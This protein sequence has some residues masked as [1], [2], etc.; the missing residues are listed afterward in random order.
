MSQVDFGNRSPVIA[1]AHM[2]RNVGRNGD[3][4][5]SSVPS[6][7]LSPLIP[8]VTPGYDGRP[9]SPGGGH[10]Q[11]NLTRSSSRNEN[12]SVL[13]SPYSEIGHAANLNWANTPLPP[14][15]PD[16]NGVA[17]AGIARSP[18]A[19]GGGF[20][21]GV[22]HSDMRAYQ[23]ALEADSDKQGA[24]GRLSQDPGNDPPP[25]YFPAR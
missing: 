18:S 9:L 16:A 6:T 4:S 24:S 17:T 14:L 22:L 11:R 20:A 10:S 8:A 1:A 5:Y 2:N 23:K 19:N 3:S 21:A 13:T 15:P 7:P 12:G 25:S